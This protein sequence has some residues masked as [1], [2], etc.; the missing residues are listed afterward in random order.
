MVLA[1]SAVRARG[2]SQKTCLPAFA[3]SM[4]GSAC[5]SFGPPLSKSWIRL[6]SSIFRQSV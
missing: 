4:H 5:V 1:S 3:A 6:S 2:F